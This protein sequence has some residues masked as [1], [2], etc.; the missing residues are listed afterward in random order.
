MNI[1]LDEQ[2]TLITG[3]GKGIGYAAA[4]IFYESGSTIALL[5]RNIDDLDELKYEF[6]IPENRFLFAEG[7]ASDEDLV[8]EFV[9]DVYKKFGRI[10]NLI[11]NAGVRFR[12]KFSE[13]SYAEWNSVIHTNL[14]SP[15]I[16][17]KAVL[18][19]MVRQNSGRIINIASIAGTLALPELSAYSASK[20]AMLS[21]TKSLALEYA[22]KNININA[23]APGFCKTSYFDK[24][25]E[26]ES[27]Y[28]FTI[29]RTPLKKW[30]ES[31]DIANACLFLASNLSNYLTGETISVDGGWSAW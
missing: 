30:G 7:D 13:I 2:V 20:A 6:N 15:F 18:P 9:V 11:N 23:I 21:L 1:R 14:G 25:K 28:N 10:D 26:N 22:D 16:C 3:A 19:I 4:K 5:T 27:L 17:S 24:F 8:N 12:K 31:T 29:D